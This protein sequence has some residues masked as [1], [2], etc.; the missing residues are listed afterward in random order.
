M[1]NDRQGQ[2]AARWKRAFERELLQV[3][4]EAAIV[5]Q[6]I[7]NDERCHEDEC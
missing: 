6:R 4:T 1:Q 5:A 7:D 3:D 2:D